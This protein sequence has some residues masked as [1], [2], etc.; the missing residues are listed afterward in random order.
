MPS[1]SSA[2]VV[3]TAA[4]LSSHRRIHKVATMATRSPPPAQEGVLPVGRAGATPDDELEGGGAAG[5][6]ANERGEATAADEGG[7]DGAPVGSGARR[8][9]TV[10][11]GVA[12]FALQGGRAGGAIGGDRPRDTRRAARRRAAAARRRPRRC[13]P[14]HGGVPKGGRRPGR[15]RPRLRR[16][17]LRHLRHVQHRVQAPEL[18][19]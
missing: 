8:A 1:L 18:S 12:G 2:K 3:A 11:G 19:S 17:W 15:G 4:R 9:V 16:W 13:L 6:A 10:G 7:D 14:R 5:E